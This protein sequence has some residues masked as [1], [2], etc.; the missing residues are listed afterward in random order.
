MKHVVRGFTIVELIVVVVVIAALAALSIGSYNGTQLRARDAKIIDAA[1]KVKDAVQLFA[2]AQGHFPAGG[3]GSS[4]GIGST[5]EC[6][7]GAG[8]WFGTGNAT[9][10][11][12]DTLVASKYLATGFSSQAKYNPD[13]A[14]TNMTMTLYLVDATAR[15]AILFYSMER[16]SSADTSHKASE[17]SRCAYTM[18]AIDTA[19][20]NAVCFNY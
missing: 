2:S 3:A 17:V 1:D 10:T 18:T 20:E 13:Y 9:C 7:N 19:L 6:A 14:G 12:E 5:T 11:V 15:T 4:S 8:G 16:P